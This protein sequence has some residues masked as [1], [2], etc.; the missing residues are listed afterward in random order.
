M[1]QELPNNVRTDKAGCAGNLMIGAVRL[2]VG[3]KENN[4]VQPRTRMRGMIWGLSV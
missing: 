2:L 4:A 3:T 1:P